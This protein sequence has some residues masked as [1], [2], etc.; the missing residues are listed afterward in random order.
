MTSKALDIEEIE[1]RLRSLPATATLRD[2]D[3][4]TLEKLDRFEIPARGRAGYMPRAVPRPQLKNL[5]VLAA[6]L[7]MVVLA[8]L[9]AVYF[10]PRYGRALADTPG[11]GNISGRFLQAVGL[12]PGD[13]TLVGDSS[14][15]AGHT[16][17]LEAAYADGVRTVLFVSIDGKGLSG[18]P[19]EY[20]PKPGDWGISYDGMTLSDQF[21]HS[22]DARGMGGPTLIQFQPL[23]WPASDVGARLTLHI[24]GLWAQWKAIEKGPNTVSDPEE[25]AVHG[26]WYLHATV[27]SQP[28]HTIAS[29]APVRTPAVVYTFTSIVA[30]GTTLVVHYTIAGPVN[31]RLQQAWAAADRSKPPSPEYQRLQEG[32]FSPR[33]YDAQGHELQMEGYGAEWPKEGGAAKADATVFIPGPGRYRIQ[34]AAALADPEQQRW[35]VVP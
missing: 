5:T 32:Y 30:S 10:A 35:I 9:P 26:D 8:N 17:K 1:E 22:Y 15:S 16:L 12:S 21:G 28:A 14:T 3:A 4:W 7:V 18:N 33:V 34:L 23:G 24:T 6:I 19:K 20:G 27:V 13:V 25:Y 31:D 2:E 11:I 29:P